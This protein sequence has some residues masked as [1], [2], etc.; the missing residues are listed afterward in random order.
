MPWLVVANISDLVQRP[1]PILS[2]FRKNLIDVD[3]VGASALSSFLGW[4][5]G[6][7][8][9]PNACMHASS[10]SSSTAG[11]QAFCSVSNVRENSGFSGMQRLVALLPNVVDAK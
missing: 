2:A 8:K 1:K 6:W 11:F 3:V 4:S 10:F 9:W 7:S 5:I